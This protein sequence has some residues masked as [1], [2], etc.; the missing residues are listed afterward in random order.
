[1]L[2]Q[3][4]LLILLA[5]SSV[6]ILFQD[7][8]QRLVSL[9]AIILFGAVCITSVV[10][11]RGFNVLFYNLVSI[12]LY[13]S[14]IWA[15]LKLYF[16]LKFKRNKPILDEQIGMADILIIVFIGLTFNIV[17]T[18]FFFCLAFIASLVSFYIYTISRKK[19]EVLTIPL[20][21]FLVFFYLSGIAVL[22]FLENNYL[23]D[24]SF[25]TPSFQ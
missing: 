5:A 13:F 23:I 7:F 3:Y 2:L 16:Y 25:V 1:M 9:W 18:I 24:C 8:K 17:G 15:F 6:I 10:Y 4:L 12:A 11:Y 21:G 19:Q 14:I 20:A 22:N